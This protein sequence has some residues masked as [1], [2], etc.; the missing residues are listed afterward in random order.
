ME[1]GIREMCNKLSFDDG[2]TKVKE[3]FIDDQ[4]S[5]EDSSLD[6][7]YLVGKLMG[8]IPFSLGAMKTALVKAWLVS[9]NLDIKEIG[10]IMFLFRFDTSFEKS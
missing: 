3:V 8:H 10:E 6:Q 9:D 1:E 7:F 4:S 2:E 5:T